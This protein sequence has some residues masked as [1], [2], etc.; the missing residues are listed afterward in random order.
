MVKGGRYAMKKE[1]LAVHDRFISL[2]Q[3]QPGILGAWYFGSAS[4]DQ[5]D[6]H[7]DL[8]VVFLANGAQF[9]D[10]ASQLT[11]WMASCC[12]SVILCWPEEF[13]GDS[14]VNNGYLLKLDGQTV[15]YD[16]FLLN[17]ERLRDGICQMHYAGLQEKSI[18]FDPCGTVRALAADAPSG[19]LWHADVLRL[20]DTYWYHAHLSAKYLIRRDFFKLEAVLRTMM[21]AHASL[22]LTAH[23][24][25]PWGG[26]ANKL[27]L[28]PEAY[29]RHL[30]QYGCLDD[31][32]L[33]R[34][35]ILQSMR[36]FVSD[37]AAIASCDAAAH[38]GNVSSVVLSCWIAATEALSSQK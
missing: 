32:T 28:L 22:L 4:R 33:M 19:H 10:I 7:S 27:R 9:A 21:D 35:R 31:F 18:I 1:L 30:M 36:W 5:T 24:T 2:M 17:S 23:D 12:D 6:D 29:Q 8:D 25:I 38:A 11:H 26:S 34:E 16:V 3:G 37:A 13:N 14:I 20:I 15:V